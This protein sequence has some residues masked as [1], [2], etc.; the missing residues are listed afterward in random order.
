MN[1]LI[2]TRPESLNDCILEAYTHAVLANLHDLGVDKGTKRADAR[3]RV[4]IKR[5]LRKYYNTLSN[6]MINY[7]AKQA[8]NGIGR[9]SYNSVKSSEIG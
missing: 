7:I 3:L 8:V 1:Y 5:N 6:V 2:E 9:Y 4:G